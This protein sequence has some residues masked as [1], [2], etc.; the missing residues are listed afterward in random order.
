MTHYILCLDMYKIKYRILILSHRPRNILN[1]F[2]VDLHQIAAT[3]VPIRI[4]LQC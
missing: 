3:A 4:I 1:A 2:I